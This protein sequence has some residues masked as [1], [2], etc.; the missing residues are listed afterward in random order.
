MFKTL[1]ACYPR[2][3]EAGEGQ[4]LPRPSPSQPMLSDPQ[5]FRRLALIHYRPGFPT[6]RDYP[7]GDGLSADIGTTD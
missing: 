6:R 1:L 2:T 4:P 3:T 7:R 5:Y